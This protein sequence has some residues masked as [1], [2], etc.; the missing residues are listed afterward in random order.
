MLSAGDLIGGSPLVSALLHDEPTI[1]LMNHLGLDVHAVG[2]HEFDEGHAEL[3]RMKAGGCHPKDGCKNGTFEGAEFTILAANVRKGSETIFPAYEIR[4][5]DGVPV[6]FIGM[7]LEDTPSFVPPIIG[8]LSF[9][10]E[11]ETV[12][13]LLPKL[14]DV[15]AI[16]VV[17]HEGGIPASGGPNDCEGVSGAIVEIAEKLPPEV[18]V[19]MSGH[20]HRA[21][22]C[23]LSGKIVTSAGCFGELLTTVDLELDRETKEVVGAVAKNHSVDHS[24]DPNAEV[25]AMVQ[26]AEKITLPLEQRVIGRI[27]APLARK[28]SEAGESPLGSV[29][30]DAQLEA[31]RGASAQI[32]FMN[33]GGIRTDL[34]TDAHEITYGMAFSVQPFANALVTMTLTG[35]QIH[36]LLEEQWGEKRARFLQ[37][38]SSLSYVWHADRERGDHVDPEEVLIDGEP[39]D[40][41][42]PYRVTVNNYLAHRGVLADGADRVPGVVDLDA[43][44]AWFEKHAPLP[45]PKAGRIRMAP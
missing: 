25:F 35:E 32:A 4:E 6:A 12:K 17:L 36:Q 14:G 1:E 30:A 40:L 33:S 21:Y 8:E 44:E 15:K 10:D 11:V 34:G 37:V 7:T 24:L 18:D 19:I 20:T 16:V 26:R 42:K 5:F 9:D 27:E 43:L 39:L 41:G 31:T 22:N 3:M 2:N 29:I 28:Q 38:S 23:K 45:S 13:A